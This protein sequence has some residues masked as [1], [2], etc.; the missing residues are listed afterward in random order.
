MLGPTAQG[1]VLAETWKGAARDVDDAMVLLL[2]DAVEAGV[3]LVEDG[4]CRAGSG[5][6]GHSA[7]SLVEPEGGRA[8]A[9]ASA[10]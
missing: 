7:T 8:C 6:A 2:S 5:N 1:R 9:V 10:A 4:C 3:H